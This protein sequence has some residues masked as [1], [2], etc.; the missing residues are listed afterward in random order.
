M[1]FGPKEKISVGTKEYNDFW[2]FLTKY[3]QSL[4]SGKNHGNNSAIIESMKSTIK[5]DWMDIDYLMTCKGSLFKD[6]EY[7]CTNSLT[8]ERVT[9][10]RDIILLYLNFLEKKRIKTMEKLQQDKENLPIFQYKQNI[11]DTL[12]THSVILVAGDTGCGKSTQV[13]QYLLEAGY[14]NIACT[15][16]RRIACISLCKRVTF[17]TADAFGSLIGYQIRFERHR[18]QDTRILFIT[19]GLMLRQVTAD[20]L[21]STY[22][23]IILDEVHE[24][25]L[26]IDFLLGLMKCLLIQR[27]NDLKVILMSATINVDLFSNYFGNCPVIQVPGRLYPIQLYYQPVS[28][29]SYKRGNRIN[30]EPYLRLLKMI[31]DKYPSSERGDVLIFLSGLTDIQTIAD[32]CKPYAGESRRWII[33]PL[34]SSLSLEEQDRIFDLAPEGVR[35]VILSTNIAETSVTIDGI[36]FVIDSGKVKEMSY[37]STI[38]MARLKEFWISK[39]SA[40]QRKGRAG[41]TGPGVCYRLYGPVSFDEMSSYSTSEINR[42]P[43]DSLLLRMIEMG[44]PDVRK[45]PFIESPSD[46]SIDQA[47]TS[48]LENG[49]LTRKPMT[50]DNQPDNE[51]GHGDFCITPMGRMLAKLPVDIVIGKMLILGSTFNLIEPI[52]SMGA[53]L[54]VQSPLTAKGYSHIDCIE[55][56]RGLDTTEGDPFLLLRAYNKWLTIKSSGSEDSRKWCKR[57][58]FEE[59]RFYEITKLRKQFRDVIKESGLYFIHRGKMIIPSRN[60]RSQGDKRRSNE[61]GPGTSTERI[62]RHGELRHLMTLKRQ[63]ESKGP[64]KRKI[65]KVNFDWEAEEEED[66]DNELTDDYDLKEIDFRLSYNDRQIKLLKNSSEI[67]KGKDMNLMKMIITSGLYPQLAIPDQHNSYKKDSDQLFHTKAKPFVVLHP[68]SVYALDPDLLQLNDKRATIKEKGIQSNQHYLLAYLLLLETTKPYLVNCLKVPAVHSMLL[69]ATSIDTNYNFTRLVLDKWIEIR[70]DDNHNLPKKFISTAIQVRDLWLNLLTK[71]FQESLDRDGTDEDNVDDEDH[72]HHSGG[73]KELSPEV[74]KMKDEL[75]TLID[76][77]LTI[78]IP[79]TIKRLLQADIDKLYIGCDSNQLIDDD[80]NENHNQIKTLDEKQS[81]DKI[82]PLKEIKNINLNPLD[83]IIS[84]PIVDKYSTDPVK[85]GIKV[86]HYLTYN[87]LSDVDVSKD[88]FIKKPWK[89]SNCDMEMITSKLE[90]IRHREKCFLSSITKPTT[91]SGQN[92]AACDNLSSN[93]PSSSSSSFKLPEDPMAKKYEC[94]LCQETF[95]LTPTGIVKHIRSHHHNKVDQV[96]EV[97]SK[98]IKIE[99]ST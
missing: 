44:L 64:K 48:L 83:E 99:Q 34:H 86:N 43:I 17:E 32:H 84:T 58:G 8:S 95:Y 36:R 46:Q 21:L 79:F 53:C 51:D 15:Q 13:P 71:V 80:G 6:D 89:C 60:R 16:P 4:E 22:N 29:D 3:L 74:I 85:G 70:L 73:G 47:L 31:D 25:H 52:I 56:R 97:K 33:L 19:E 55:A 77:F 10:F 59:Q 1:F 30:P 90:E 41:R 78:E 9:K 63:I 7:Y 39:A 49:A 72:H 50:N 66:E 35:K 96:E 11:L 2:I 62:R 68:N 94:K 20:P 40:E 38:R 28:S 98:T 18:T 42:V 14:T 75:N 67:F 81:A 92:D 24:R 57:R 26:T 54:S 12:K 87:C 5:A 93:E 37:D 45:F 27:P 23:V 76:Y 91:A 88:K 82:N 69:F 61:L 65:L